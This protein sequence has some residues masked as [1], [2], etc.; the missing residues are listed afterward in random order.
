MRRRTLLLGGGIAAVS[1]GIGYTSLVKPTLSLAD[2]SQRKK[3]SFPNLIDASVTGK[4][5]LQA[6]AGST[7]FYK[8]IASKTLGFQPRLSWTRCET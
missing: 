3:L 5:P 7:E 2:L 6:Q 4:I 8:G 1:A